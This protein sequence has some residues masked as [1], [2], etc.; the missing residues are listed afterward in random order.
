MVWD[1]PPPNPQT[2]AAPVLSCEVELCGGAPQSRPSVA[3]LRSGGP[4]LWGRG[5]PQ[6]PPRR[7]TAVHKVYC[8]LPQVRSVN[9]RCCFSTAFRVS[10]SS[11]V[12]STAVQSAVTTPAMRVRAGGACGGICGRSDEGA[13][14]GGARAVEYVGVRTKARARGVGGGLRS[15]SV[16]SSCGNSRKNCGK[17][18][19]HWLNVPFAVPYPT[20]PGPQRA[21]H[22]HGWLRMILCLFE[23]GPQVSPSPEALDP[24]YPIGIGA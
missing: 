4:A 9:W 8:R 11:S 22:L 19:E 7:P 5:P 20:L 14:A 13:R 1:P 23:H 18:W 10:N 17:L 12:S 21:T 15:G 16:K 2:P 24:P 6:S 3:H